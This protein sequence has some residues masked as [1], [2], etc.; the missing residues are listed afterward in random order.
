MKNAIYALLFTAALSQAGCSPEFWG[1]TA[2]GALGAGGGYEYQNKRQM[3][4]LEDDFR[5]GRIGREEYQDRKSQIE[6][7]SLIY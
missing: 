5:A 1:G 3:D 4:K 2:L 7:G 6:R